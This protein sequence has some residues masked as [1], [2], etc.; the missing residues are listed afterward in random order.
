MGWASFFSSF[1]GGREGN[2]VVWRI[3]H[4]WVKG[5]RRV[6]KDDNWQRQQNIQ[7]SARHIFIDTFGISGSLGHEQEIFGEF[8]VGLR[9]SF[10]G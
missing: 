6:L 4:L 5:R 2:G 1:R 10:F 3:H 7:I 8:D 9:E